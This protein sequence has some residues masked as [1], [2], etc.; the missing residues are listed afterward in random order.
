VPHSRLHI[1]GRAISIA[2]MASTA[3]VSL[4]VIREVNANP[5]TDDAEV[6]ANFIG[7]AP[8]VSGPVTRLY[9]SDN[10]L[11]NAGAPLFDIDDRPYA[12]ALARARSDQIALQG[13]IGDERRIIAGKASGVDVAKSNVLGADAGLAHAEA[14][15]QQAKADVANSQAAV[16]RSTA[17][18]EYASNNLHRIEPLLAR[19]F[20]TVDQVDQARTLQTS[21]LQAAN[22]AR[23]Q[24]ALAEA[25]LVASQAQ[26]K[27]AQALVEQSHQQVEQASHN[28]TTLQPLEGQVSGK[29]AATDTANYN[30]DNCHIVAPFDARVTNLTISEGA[31]ANAGEHIFTLIDTRTWWVIANFRETQ[32]HRIQ[33]GMLADVYVMSRPSVRYKGVVDSVGFGVTPDTDLVGRLA[34]PGLPDVQ[35]TLNWVHLASRFPVRVRIQNPPSEVFR[36]GESAVVIIRGN[37]SP[38]HRE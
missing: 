16:E 6:F 7:M 11:V 2:I 36:L 8:L 22:Q 10:Q 24:L 27:Q 25:G 14:A 32:L 20:V 17:E 13:E 5:R 37:P 26:L 19:Q 21:R 23:S 12:Y 30:F 4:L 3:I 31:Y 1:I 28:V 33:P 38:E 34:A 9:V 35:R 18:L 15:V 29:Q